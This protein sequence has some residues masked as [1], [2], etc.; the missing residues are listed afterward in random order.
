MHT[1]RLL[2]VEDNPD[3]ADLVLAELR[4]AGVHLEWTR[5]ETE[6][7]FLAALQNP[8]DIILSDYSMP[9]FSGFRALELLR[10]SGQDVPFILISGTVG[11]EL[12][13]QAMRD[14]ATDY[15][16]KDRLARLPSAV[17]RALS[18][19]QVRAERNQALAAQARLAAI[20]TSSEDAIIGKTLDGIITSWNGGAERLF[21]YTASEAVGQ[22]LLMLFPPERLDEEAEILARVASGQSVR[23]FETV[24]VRKDGRRID[25]SI[26]LS[27]IVDRDG[28]IIGASK[29]ARDITERNRAEEAV[30]TSNA[31]TA[32]AL[33]SADVGIWDWDHITG[34][35][36]WSETMEHHYGLSAGSFGGT[37][38]AFSERIHPD[39]RQ[40]LVDTI[41]K[42]VATGS[43][44]SAKHRAVWPDGTVR[45]LTGAGRILL[46][47]NRQPVRG[48]GISQDV[49]ER[50]TLEEQFQQAQ[51]MEAIGRLA[52]GVAHDF[53][54]LLTAILGFCELLLVERP[55]DDPG[56]PD[57][58]EIKKAATRA[59]GLTKQLLAFSRKQIIEPTLLDLNAVVTELRSMLGRLIGEDVQV[60]L[61]LE[62]T[63]G[64][65]KADRGQVEQIIM[66]LA[67]NA[68]D[69][70]PRGGTL[71]IKTM[72][73]VLDE[74]SMQTRVPATPG[75]YVA[76]I[77]SDTGTGMTP[78]VQARLFEPFFT[79]KERGEGTGLGM[80]TVYGIVTRSG[81]SL[82]VKT[83][84]GKGTIFTVYF[85][86]AHAT[87]PVPDAPTLAP[88]PRTRTLTIL[89][90]DDEDGIRELAKRLL[91]RLGYT[92]LVAATPDEALRRSDE[93]PT[94]DILLTDVVM[95]GSS[96]PDLAARLIE[97]RPG[98]RVIYMSGYA[99]HSIVQH[100]VLGPGVAFLSKPYTSETL[101]GK[102]RELLDR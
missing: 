75:P 68:R 61:L 85:P 92:V 12:A 26:T 33:Q 63:L 31:R 35:L 5:V 44:F 27:P 16:L 34:A 43:D 9:Q 83:E 77:V 79:T 99:E 32:F 59:A 94:I 86:T 22:P 45:W 2:I 80:A 50:H 95:P 29:I 18:E 73:V 49:T 37:I 53:N 28:R 57:I 46:D 56:R 93:N 3:D 90:V 11:E 19:T 101:V 38:E 48:V 62:S 100:G 13:V 55:A 40:S 82:G 24:R 88:L 66:N 97:R 23:H 36:Q 7:D 72:N 41:G 20:V 30:R 87:E 58:A 10:S 71:T 52:G 81:G 21:G 91:E 96:G 74:H 89:V 70:M 17:R 64:L 25:V 4:R 69:A 6:Q 60:V 1:L 84:V 8:H 102:I 54:N 78:E 65:V 15:L 47:E 39:D 51:K 67:V 76:L 42:A 14:G 98:L